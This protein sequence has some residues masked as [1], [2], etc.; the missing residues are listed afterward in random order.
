MAKALSEKQKKILEFL[1]E[2]IR[3]KGYPPSVREICNAVGLKSTSTVHGYLERLEKKGFIRRDPAKPRAIEIL[4]DTVFLSKKELVNVP[5]VGR[6][7]AGQPIL[8]VENIEDTFPIPVEYLKNSDVFML[9]VRGESMIN[10][11]ILD[12]DYVI[13]QKQ[14]TAQNGDMIV[15]LIED[16]ATVKTFYKEKDHIRLQPENPNMEPILVRDVSIL[17]K[18]IGVIRMFH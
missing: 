14:S 9:S 4:D 8:A 2:E 13:V 1:K 10:A 16:E 3:T 6:V 7:T 11:G 12:G 5:I 17:G 18:V 15:A